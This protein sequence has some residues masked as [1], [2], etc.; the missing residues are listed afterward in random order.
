MGLALAPAVEPSAAT[1]WIEGFLRG[2]GLIL[3]H[4]G[5]LWQILDEWVAS[6]KSEAFML[7]L[8]LLRRTFSTFAPPERRQLGERLTRG[9]NTGDVH[10]PTD[11][12]AIDIERANKVLPLAAQLLGLDDASS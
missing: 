1:S 8:P 2:S 6:L 5:E 7:L 10:T 11:A 4:N 9:R 3:L 12:V